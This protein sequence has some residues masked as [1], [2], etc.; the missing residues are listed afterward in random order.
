M[1]LSPEAQRVVDAS[2]ARMA[3]PMHETPV[4]DL[5]AA[6]AAHAIPATTPIHH[7]QDSVVPSAGGGVPVRIY[8]PPDDPGLAVVQGMHSG[9]FAV[10][11]L[12]QNEEYLRKLSIASQAVIVSVHYRLAPQHPCPPALG[13]CGRVWEWITS[14]PDGLRSVDGTRVVIACERAGRTLT[15]ALAQHLREARRPPPPAQISLDAPAVTEVTNPEYATA[16]L[17]PEDWHR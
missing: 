2:A 16:L 3:K 15:F 4:E 9:G 12:D 5:R 17:S 11:N 14:V 8:R 1:S 7:R 13:A 10:G 6:L